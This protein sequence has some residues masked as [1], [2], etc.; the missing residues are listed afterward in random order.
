MGKMPLLASLYPSL[1]LCLLPPPSCLKPTS[2]IIWRMFEAQRSEER[3]FA[4]K[5]LQQ[6]TLFLPRLVWIYTCCVCLSLS[7]MTTHTHAQH[8][9]RYTSVLLPHMRNL[10]RLGPHKKTSFPN[11]FILLKYF[12]GSKGSIGLDDG[13][14]RRRRKKRRKKTVPRAAA[15]YAR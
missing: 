8:R 14:R 11:C 2:A 7:A 4:N 15:G 9:Y 5:N 1:W 12:C 6:L 3:R 13:R 10:T